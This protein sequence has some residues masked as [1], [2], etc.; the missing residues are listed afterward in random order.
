FEW[1]APATGKNIA[2]FGP[3]G[4]DQAAFAK[5]RVVTI[6]ECG[7]HAMVDARIGG[8]G[9]NGGGGG[10][11]GRGARRGGGGGGGRGPGRGR[12]CAATGTSTT[13]TTGVPR[14]IPARRCCG[15]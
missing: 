6:S 7:S 2:A 9:G 12:C 11:R 15:G 4:Q 3:A 14:R 13:G 10:G 1:D 5:A 8:G